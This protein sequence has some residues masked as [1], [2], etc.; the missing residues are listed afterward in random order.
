M[1][2][3]L[4]H[5]RLYQMVALVAFALLSAGP[6]ECLISCIS[7]LMIVIYSAVHIHCSNKEKSGAKRNVLNCAASAA[8]GGTSRYATRLHSAADLLSRSSD[9]RRCFPSALRRL[10]NVKLLWGAADA[11]GVLLGRLWNIYLLLSA[12][13][14]LESYGR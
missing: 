8:E 11:L 10:L 4:A 12:A 14:V 13:D 2:Q 5:T 1:A 9:H 3:E 6:K 7:E